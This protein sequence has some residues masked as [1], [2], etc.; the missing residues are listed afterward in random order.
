MER[1]PPKDPWHFTAA[2]FKQR[3]RD[4]W[5]AIRI[6]LLVEA[7]AV[8]TFLAVP[9][10]HSMRDMSL[11]QLNTLFG[12]FVVMGAAIIAITFAIKRH[13]RCPK[14]EAIPMNSWATLGPSTFGVYSG[15]ALN[16]S[17]CRK[18]GARLR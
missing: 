7:L 17:V 5:K 11:W 9:N 18:C 3:R 6:W 2:A 1:H 4:T 8:A 14:C 15:V 13:Y 10:A 16:P 12:A